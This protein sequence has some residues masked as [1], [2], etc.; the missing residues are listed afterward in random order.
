MLLD[1]GESHVHLAARYYETF[2][3]LGPIPV[4]AR[5]KAL[6]CDS[7]PPEI[8]GSKPTGASMTVCCE[9]CVWSGRGLCDEPITR[10]E[11]SF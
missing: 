3:E 6:L 10:P 1:Y 2:K 5:S 11:E 9:C 4:A 8:M 7:S